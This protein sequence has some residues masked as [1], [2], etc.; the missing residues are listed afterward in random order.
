MN[1]NVN[2]KMVFIIGVTL[3]LG[4]CSCGKKSDENN[5]ASGRPPELN[6]IDSKIIGETKTESVTENTIEQ[7]TETKESASIESKEENNIDNL[8]EEAN[9]ELEESNSLA[10]KDAYVA[11]I[12]QVGSTDYTYSL[13]YIDEDDVPELVID[14]MYSAEGVHICTYDGE[15]V[16][17]T[18]VGDY[19]YYT[20]KGNVIY[21]FGGSMDYYYD[22][23]Y[24]IVDG[25]PVEVARGEYGVFDYEN[26]KYDEEGYMIYEYS[27]NG[28]RISEYEYYT[29]LEAYNTDDM[30][31]SGSSYMHDMLEV[32]SHPLDITL[33]SPY[34]NNAGFESLLNHYVVMFDGLEEDKLHFTVTY[35][36]TLIG[37]GSATIIDTNT[38]EYKNANSDLTIKFDLEY[39]ELK[40]EGY[41][42]TID[43]TGTYFGMWG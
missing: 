43:L 4:I 32:L 14:Y 16:I 17:A 40:M 26:I 23:I 7:N 29:C 24:E 12:N 35:D 20:P 37:S 41:M 10:W 5:I 39:S 15:K 19:F 34:M 22:V 36:G 8:P 18:S 33:I 25:V 21:A 30:R 3:C 13:D 28:D 42:G 27:W 9:N 11:Y 1:N 2:K 31:E 6:A 38:A